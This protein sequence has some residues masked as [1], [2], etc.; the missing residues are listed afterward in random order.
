MNAPFSTAP[1]AAADQRHP[2]HPPAEQQPV[3]GGERAG[4]QDED[5]GVVQPLHHPPGGPAGD[6]H[7][8]RPAEGEQRDA[9]GGVHGEQRDAGRVAPPPPHE[10]A[11]QHGERGRP[12]QVAD[13][14][15]RVVETR[16]V[17]QV[18]HAG[19]V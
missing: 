16:Q 1:A 15:E 8:V 2:A 18:G 10:Q 6:R 4:D 13:R 14:A 17:V 3:R 19:G 11:P 5:R 12:D 9:R 7:V